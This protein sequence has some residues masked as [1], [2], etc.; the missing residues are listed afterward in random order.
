M[1]SQ[2]PTE[3]A[4]E[5]A[6]ESILDSLGGTSCNHDLS[7]K[8]ATQL[9]DEL[10]GTPASAAPPAALKGPN[11]PSN[12][13]TPGTSSSVEEK[14]LSLLGSGVQAE[15]V[16]SALGVTPSR[17]AQLLSDKVFSD[18]VAE[19]R[20]KSLQEHNIRDGKYDTLEDTLL[21]KLERSLPLL[22]R[23]ESILKAIGVVN[24][25][26]RRGQSAPQ[27]VTNQQNIVNLV[28][29][30]VIAEKFAININ[31]QVTKA[32]DQE[33]LTMASGNL[34]KQIEDAASARTLE[35]TAQETENVSEVQTE[36]SQPQP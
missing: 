30:T 20:Y 26:K 22:V 32:G 10:L 31:N 23:P 18:S 8:E 15:S 33:L 27:Q 25:A 5:T 21:T 9:V 13:Y 14:A 19:L 12:H 36:R 1:N 6:A 28:L 11:T 3:A 35:H 34:L 7:K 4:A 17:I 2:I 16:A 24:S 29:P